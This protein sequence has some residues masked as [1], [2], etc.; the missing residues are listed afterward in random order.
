MYSKF[1]LD[2]AHNKLMA[3]IYRQERTYSEGFHKINNIRKLI[4]KIHLSGYGD[5][6]GDAIKLKLKDEKTE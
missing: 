5:G 3:I 6:F 4:T 1:D 2:K